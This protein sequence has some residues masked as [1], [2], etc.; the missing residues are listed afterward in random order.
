MKT[1]QS[2]VVQNQHSQAVAN[3]LSRQKDNNKDIAVLTKKNDNTTVIMRK[4]QVS[5]RNTRLEEDYDGESGNKATVLNNLTTSKRGKAVKSRLDKIDHSRTD[6][7]QFDCAEPHALS[8]FIDDTSDNKVI[9]D[10]QSA[11]VGDPV[12]IRNNQNLGYKKPCLTCRQWVAGKKGGFRIGNRIIPT[13][14]NIAKA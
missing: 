11:K 5:M 1:M 3:N 4:V 14:D 9:S 12:E 8:Q 7:D 10:L 2:K 6:W 13:P